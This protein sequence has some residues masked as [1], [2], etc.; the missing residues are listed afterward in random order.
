MGPITSIF[1]LEAMARK[2]LPRVIFDFVHGGSA[3]ELTLQRNLDD[4]RALALRQHDL[5]D[6]SDRNSAVTMAGDPARIPLAIGPTGL[7]GLTWANGECEAARAA[8]Q[9]GV[10]YC[11]ST[12]SICSIEDVAQATPKPFWFQL[13]LM[14]Q[15]EVNENLIR[16]AHEAGC[17]AL[18]LTLDLHV[19]GKRWADA[20]NGLAV[21]PRL[22]L[23]NT[24]DILAHPGWL[25]SMAK[26]KRRTFGN[27]EGE[28]KQAKNLSALSEWIAAQFDP[29]FDLET[30]KWVRK[31]WQRKLI[32][33]G[34]MH[35]DDARLAV[36]V[37]ADAIVVSNHGGRQLDSAP[38]S[39]S[40]LPE[41]AGA[42]REQL[43]V[44]F[45]GGIRTG[46]DIVKALGRGAHACLSGRACL[47]GLAAGGSAGVACA[48]TLLE[49]ELNDCMA[50]TG[51]N[52]VR[53]VGA[54]VVTAQPPL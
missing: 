45:D 1:D 52:D 19:Q 35:V 44:F 26:S 9:F 48:L 34:I 13:Y 39:I 7:A 37:G 21:P 16:R 3:Q 49:D 4:L 25:L 33:K 29:S 28:V 15:H 36:D 43:E 41:I 18:V 38:S 10:P 40:I 5:R 11:L 30:V 50:L 47:Y 42:V 6:V 22:T 14:K 27:L 2:R 8:A 32:L 17:S 20:K 23:S 46:A 31:L 24:M 51:L 53:D 12:M 54:G